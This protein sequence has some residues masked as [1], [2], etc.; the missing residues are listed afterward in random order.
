MKHPDDPKTIYGFLTPSLKKRRDTKLPVFTIMSCDNIQ[1]NGD[2]ARDTVVS[3]AK[4][5]DD[6][7]AQWI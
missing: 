3:F 5:Q 4:R 2:V 7:M 1:H 6:S